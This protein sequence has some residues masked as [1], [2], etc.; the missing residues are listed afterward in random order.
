MGA[1]SESEAA[2]WFGMDAHLLQTALWVGLL[3]EWT[4]TPTV[5]AAF[6]SGPSGTRSLCVWGL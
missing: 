4:I 1:V 5:T 2:D 3:G 6:E